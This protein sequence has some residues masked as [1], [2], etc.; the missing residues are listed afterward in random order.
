[1]NLKIFTI[2]CF[3]A[4]SVIATCQTDSQINKTDQQGRKQGHWIKRYPNENILY[5]G[6]FKDEHPVGEFKRFFENQSLK[7][8]LLYSGDGKEAKATMY[9]PNGNI[10]SKGIYIDQMKEGKWQF[11]SAFTKGYMISEEFY[12]KNLKNGWSIKFYI[13]ST[14]AEKLYYINGIRQGEWIQ[15]YPNRIVS[16]KSNYLHG[17]INGQFEVWFENGAIELSGQYKNDL[18]DGLWL[19]YNNNGTIKYKLE[20]T[21][22]ITKD[23]QIDIDES[24][25][26]DS[27]ERNQGK[28]AD[29]EKIGVI[30]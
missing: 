25:Y 1:M 23:V 21:A 8:I 30:K 16:L 2:V 24:N 7:S 14:I 27:L 15:Y 10:S 26:L 9:H 19:I 6:L 3:L 5:D 17:K 12:S 29:P 22:G 11:Y 13:D 20:Y 28:I 4:V 18:R